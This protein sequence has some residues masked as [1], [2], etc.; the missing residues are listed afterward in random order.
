MK[1]F[2][3]VVFTT[4]SLITGLF[5]GPMKPDTTVR[6]TL[7]SGNRGLESLDETEGKPDRQK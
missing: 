1:T 2:T 4:L 3:V 5:E 7:E 6:W